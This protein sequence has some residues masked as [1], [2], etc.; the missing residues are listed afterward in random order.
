M[1]HY[2]TTELLSVFYLRYEVD[3]LAR[4]EEIVEALCWTLRLSGEAGM[5]GAVDNVLKKTSQYHITWQGDYNDKFKSE[6]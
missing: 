3:F 1:L 4:Y 5:G 2:I 6:I